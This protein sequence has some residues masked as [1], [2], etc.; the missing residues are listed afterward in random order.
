VRIQSE[1]IDVPDDTVITEPNRV[2]R[3]IVWPYYVGGRTM[4]RCFMPG[5]MT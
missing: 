4:I 1:W 5:S 3:T 2:G